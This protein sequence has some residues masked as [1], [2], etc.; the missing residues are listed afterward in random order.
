MNWIK[1]ISV[2]KFA[3]DPCIDPTKI[4]KEAPEVICKDG[5]LENAHRTNNDNIVIGMV[6][7]Q[8]QA[9]SNRASDLNAECSKRRDNG[10]GGG[11]GTIFA[12]VAKINPLL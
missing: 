7:P 1:F 9:G 2:N 10:Y 11:M 5:K 4:P 8:G 12:E 6:Q 3:G